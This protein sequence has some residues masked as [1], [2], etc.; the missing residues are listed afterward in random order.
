MMVNP[1]PSLA[2]AKTVKAETLV[3]QGDCGHFS[4]LCEADKVTSA[5][6][7]FLGRGN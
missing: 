7:S 1:E 4:F 3:L 6:S 2:L 5:A